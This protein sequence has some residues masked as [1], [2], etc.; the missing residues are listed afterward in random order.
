MAAA[1]GFNDGWQPGG[2]GQAIDYGDP[3]LLPHDNA[4]P[5]ANAVAWSLLGV[6]G[7][8]LGLRVYCKY[9]GHRRLWW[10]DRILIASWVSLV[11]LNH[12]RVLVC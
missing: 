10:D 9:Y 6:A 12:P 7:V 8:F 1:P 4:G 2:P 5:E 11:L 3:A